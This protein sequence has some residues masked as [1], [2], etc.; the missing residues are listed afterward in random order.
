MSNEENNLHLKYA[1]I[2]ALPMLGSRLPK[3]SLSS[4]QYAMPFNLEPVFINQAI[5]PFARNCGVHSSQAPRFV[6]YGTI[7]HVE[8]RSFEDPLC[9]NPM[10]DAMINAAIYGNSILL[11]PE[12]IYKQICDQLAVEL[13]RRDDTANNLKTQLEQ[14]ARTPDGSIRICASGFINQKANDV[15]KSNEK[16][17]DTF[18]GTV[19]DSFWKNLKPLVE[20]VVTSMAP[21]ANT[22]TTSWPIDAK[23]GPKDGPMQNHRIDLSKKTTLLEDARFVTPRVEMSATQKSGRGNLT[24]K[25]KRDIESANGVDKLLLQGDLKAWVDLLHAVNQIAEFPLFEQWGNRLV[26]LIHHFVRYYEKFTTDVSKRPKFSQNLINRL[27]RIKEEFGQIDDLKAFV[28]EFIEIKLDDNE[29]LV[30]FGNVLHLFPHAT[31]IFFVEKPGR[32][33]VRAKRI[34]ER[35]KKEGLKAVLLQNY[36]T[37]V[38]IV[39]VTPQG[40]L[41]MRFFDG[42]VGWAYL[43]DN[44]ILGKEQRVFIP[45][46]ASFVTFGEM[47]PSRQVALSSTPIGRNLAEE[48]HAGL[49]GDFLLIGKRLEDD[50]RDVLKH[51][52]VIGSVGALEEFANEQYHD[53]S[54]FDWDAITVVGKKME[55][56]LLEKAKKLSQQEAD[57]WNKKAKS[58]GSVTD[59]SEDSVCNDEESVS[60]TCDSEIDD[61]AETDDQKRIQFEEKT[62]TSSSNE[63]DGQAKTSDESESIQV[64]KEEF[65]RLQ[66]QLVESKNQIKAMQSLIEKQSA[67]IDSLFS[68]LQNLGE[69]TDK[70]FQ[71]QAEKFEKK[72][73]AIDASV[74]KKAEE[75]MEA[76]QNLGQVVEQTRSTCEKEV[77]FWTVRSKTVENKMAELE[78]KTLRMRNNTISQVGS[79]ESL[80]EKAEASAK[81][82]EAS[83]LTAQDQASSARDSALAAEKQAS[84]ARDAA[85]AAEKQSSSARDSALAA[86]DQASSARDSALAAQDQASFA[87]DAAL[88]AEKQSSSARDAA[89]AAEKQSSSARDSALAAEKQSSS[90]RDSALSAEKQSSSARDSALAA[91]KQSSSARDSAAS[92]CKFAT[93]AKNSSSPLTLQEFGCETKVDDRLMSTCRVV[94]PSSTFSNDANVIKDFLSTVEHPTTLNPSD[95]DHRCCNHRKSA[96]NIDYFNKPFPTIFDALCCISD[97][98]MSCSKCQGSTDAKLFDDGPEESPDE[99]PEPIPE[100]ARAIYTQLASEQGGSMFRCCSVCRKEFNQDNY[101]ISLTLLGVSE[102]G[103]VRA[104]LGFRCPDFEDQ[105]RCCSLM[106]QR[107]DEEQQLATGIAISLSRVNDFNDDVV[108]RLHHSGWPFDEPS[109]KDLLFHMKDN[110]KDQKL[111]LEKHPTLLQK[112]NR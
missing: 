96:K 47:L 94:V 48:A 83:M 13:Q 58:Q 6:D 61:D 72:I 42:M 30:I 5:E 59:S 43:A 110:T 68:K 107:F 39:L 87:R 106:Y 29:Q 32:A 97:K 49:H 25:Q 105:E 92:S 51:L 67:R 14:F 22:I 17:E 18:D 41:L 45:V 7:F 27:K 34:D 73:K 12:M 65:G 15:A 103:V 71:R 101:R 88:A 11:T 78:A 31:G 46:R 37:C 80:C 54:L 55:E 64:D 111:F 44:Y 79:V 69:Q 2:Q 90:A 102:D 109:H 77:F 57:Q 112:L 35:L 82:A 20:R 91:E 38:N 4:N 26:W 81:Q 53:K 50:V 16:N 60:T 21:H 84:S 36:H 3:P 86:Q 1:R 93:Y 95:A 9:P 98:E 100:F 74:K 40:E 99:S 89:L 8:K 70:R 10:I 28:D 62:E 76:I 104:R 85:L 108:V 56:H 75:Q 23:D 63:L 24:G 52:E 19:S 33:L 66:E